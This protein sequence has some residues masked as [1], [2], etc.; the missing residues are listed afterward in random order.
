MEFVFCVG[1]GTNG[2]FCL[3][4]LK[5]WFLLPRWRVFTARYVHSRY[6]IHIRFVFEGLILESCPQKSGKNISN[7]EN[8]T[9]EP[10]SHDQ[11]TECIICEESF[12]E[13]WIQYNTCKDWAHGACVGINP[14]DLYYN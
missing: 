8:P 9:P 13:D 7:K 4:T 3:T 6:I 12:D 5:D 14:A 1:L 2:N 10:L 11:E